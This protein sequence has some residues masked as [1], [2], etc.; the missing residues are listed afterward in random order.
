MSID[1]G[2]HEATASRDDAL[3]SAYGYAL[4]AAFGAAWGSR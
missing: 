2:F 1:A 3:A 4:S